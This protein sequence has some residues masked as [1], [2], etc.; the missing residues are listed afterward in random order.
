MGIGGVRA[1]VAPENF[2]ADPQ[3]D[4]A[5]GLAAYRADAAREFA[6][7]EN[8][9]GKAFLVLKRAP[10]QRLNRPLAPQRTQTRQLSDAGPRQELP[11]D[12]VLVFPVRKT[13]RSLIDRFYSVGQTRNND[14]TIRDVS[15]SKFHAYFQQAPDGSGLTLQDSGSTNGTRL[16]GVS[17]PRQGDGEP[18]PVRSGALLRF[19]TVELTFL[20]AR[21]FYNLVRTVFGVS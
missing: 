20:S 15:V 21:D 8:L 1:S 12:R 16:D 19:G 13:E 7:F 4:E 18:M 11:P 3:P 10:Q 9:H 5:H 17:V 6:W 14:I 2:D